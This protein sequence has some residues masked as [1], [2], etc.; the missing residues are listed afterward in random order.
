MRSRTLLPLILG[1]LLAHP[2]PLAAQTYDDFI[3]PGA[4]QRIDLS[5][6]SGDWQQLKDNFADDTY[7]PARLEWNG[8]VVRNV[9]VRSRGGGS[10]SGTKPGLRVDID[11]Y[12]ST[13]RFLGVKSFV[14]DNLLQ[15]PSGIRE[16]LAMTVHAKLGIPAP[17]ET[18]ARLYV[19]NEYAGLY[20]VVEAVDKRLLARVFG[21]VEEDTQ[22]DGYLFDY[23]Y[24]DD[25]R[26]GYLGPELEPYKA[27]LQA[28]TKENRPDEEK[29]RPIEELTRLINETPA[30]R[31]EEAIGDKLDLD[32]TVRFVASQNYLAQN[33]GLVGYAGMN[34]F[35]LY[36]LEGQ[37]RHVWIAWDEDNAL[38]ATDFALDTRHGDNVLIAKLMQIPRLR[39]LY[40]QT[41]LDL[42][43]LTTEGAV[44]GN[45][46]WLQGE[47][48]RETAM[49]ADAMREDTL[50]P[51]SNAEFDAA[52]TAAAA[53][54]A[55][56]ATYVRCNATRALGQGTPTGCP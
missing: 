12:Q 9:G 34:N 50:K 56:R 31:L 49:I 15:D 36:R 51:Y 4:L 28:Q 23:A 18:H 53:F 26:F 44:G 21:I 5:I 33:D 35:Y 7:Y 46:G 10:R 11:R 40:Y 48:M 47:A 19:N 22:N 45:G 3:N 14:L 24:I 13:E 2:R 6:N 39:T 52:S 43:G 30:D 42:V 54:S 25:W 16:T 55:A 20:A 1:V 41:L 17:R 37:S 27:H 32:A 8:V 29:Y 38:S